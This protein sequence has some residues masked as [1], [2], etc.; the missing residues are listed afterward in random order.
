MQ[1][2]ST[3]N[4]IDAA[5]ALAIKSD[6]VLQTM[7]KG[8]M[9]YSRIAPAEIEDPDNVGELIKT[10]YPF[11]TLGEKTESQFNS[12]GEPGQ[13]GSLAI[14]IW[15]RVIGN[16]ETDLIYG[17]LARVLSAKLTLSTGEMFA[18]WLSYLADAYDQDAQAMHAIAE[19]RRLS[20][21]T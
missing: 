18:G 16:E 4:P 1:H 13:T 3:L 6:S 15:S 19:L 14:H 8:D 20:T 9:V 11:V 2:G 17:E 5:V 10:P 12:F 21:H 7:L